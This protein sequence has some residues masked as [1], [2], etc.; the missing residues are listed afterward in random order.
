MKR[1]DPIKCV[2]D[3]SCIMQAIE[4]KSKPLR[5]E[6]AKFMV[7]GILKAIIPTQVGAN[8]PPFSSCRGARLAFVTWSW[9]LLPSAHL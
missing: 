8:H 6:K 4:I 7:H 5:Q 3:T 1:D 2:T 9:N